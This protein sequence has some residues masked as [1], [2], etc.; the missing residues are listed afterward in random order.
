MLRLAPSQSDR[1]FIREAIDND[2][3]PVL[4][5]CRHTWPTG[6]YIADVW[7]KWISDRN[8]RFVVA[9]IKGVQVGIAH[10]YLQS[11]EV[12]WL[13][14][15]RV[16]PSYRGRGIAGKLNKALIR[17]FRLKGAKL[18]RLSTEARNIASQRHS[19]KVGFRILQTFQRFD[20]VKGLR[21]KPKLSMPRGKSAGLW[22]WL[23]KR[24]ELDEFKHMYS[25]GWSLY[26]LTSDTFRSLKRAGLVLL[27]GKARAEPEG[28]GLVSIADR[29]VTV[30][31]YAGSPEGITDHA[32]YLRYMLNG[33]AFDKA[34]V[35]VPAGSR[36]EG[37]IEEAGFGKSVKILVYEKRLE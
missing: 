2:K 3:E 25:K 8:G 18:A 14:G 20:A 16:H 1:V 36:F 28:L 34:R 5:F 24:S 17:Y 10:G 15:I 13:E 35:L 12:A 29:R 23:E 27:N 37:P 4:A 30:G 26:P 33:K 32:R 6:D 9:N 31:F 19:E 22:R 11:R 21:R 7:D